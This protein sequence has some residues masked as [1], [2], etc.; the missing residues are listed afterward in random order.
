[1]KSNSQ[2]FNK[3]AN[4][5]IELNEKKIKNSKQE[6][7]RIKSNAIKEWYIKYNI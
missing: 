1:M 3:K 6:L 4:D 7:K 2:I 5:D